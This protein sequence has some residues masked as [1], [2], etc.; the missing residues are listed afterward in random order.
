MSTEPLTLRSLREL[1]LNKTTGKPHLSAASGMWICH[2]T[3]YVVA[4]DELMLGVFSMQDDQ[5]G[6]TLTIIPG[7]LPQ[8]AKQRKAAKPDFESLTYL[9]ASALYPHA[10]LLAL[11]SGSTEQ[12]KR[13]MLWPF[14]QQQQL[15]PAPQLFDLQPLYQP[16]ESVFA[17][18]NIEGVV[19]QGDCLKLWQRANNQQRE[20]AVIQYP[21]ADMYKVINAKQHTLNLQPQRIDYY[22]LGEVAGVPLSFTD[23]YAL[24]DGACLF[25]A[26]AE[27]TDNSYLDG[28]C[29]AAAIGLIDA[30][31][32]LRW[33][34]PVQPIFKIEGISAKQIGEQ[35]Q[36][37]L[38]SDADN[39]ATAAQLLETYIQYPCE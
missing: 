9:P 25:T 6:Q 23:A 27:N 32:Q 28:E 16:L 18:L 14:N 31:H 30:Q 17:D 5:P 24:E 13:G 38:V 15:V 20:N 22:D 34:K 36:I 33:L 7:A 29:V 37:L 35:L 26:A 1:R 11:G 19:I 10:A 2:D 4:D 39:P 12:R 8:E 3:L 21:L